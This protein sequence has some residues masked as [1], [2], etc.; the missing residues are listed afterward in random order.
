MNEAILTTGTGRGRDPQNRAV[1]QYASALRAEELSGRKLA[2]WAFLAGIAVI[3][4]WL[5]LQIGAPRVY[6][7][8]AILALF[9]L[10]F[11]ADYGLSRSRHA[12]SWHPYLFSALG[13]ALLAFTLVVPNPFVENWPTQMRLRFGNFV[14][15]IVFLTPI[16]LSYSPRLMLWSGFAAVVAWGVGVAWVVALDGTVTWLDMPD[17]GRVPTSDELLAFFL[18]PG[19]VDLEARVQEIIVVLLVA[20]VL[21]LVVW[22]SRRLVMRQ[23][24]VARER[25]NLARYFPP[26]VVDQLADLDEPFGEVRSQPVAVMFADIVGFSKLAENQAPDEVIAVLR[27]F[28][29]RLE[30]DIF[31]HG[32]TLDKFLGDGVMATFGTPN[33][34]PQDAAHALDCA[35]AILET[36]GQWNAERAARGEAA[37]KVSIGIHYGE[38]VLGDI[39]SARRLEFA[40]LGDVVNVANRLE[41]LT[42][43]LGCRLVV[44]DAVVQAAKRQAGEAAETLITGL[45]QGTPQSLRGRVEPVGIWTFAPVQ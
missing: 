29:A 13:I 22:R 40:V 30:R 14:Y 19:F 17:R 39:G 15:M 10:I 33:T 31:D 34:G 36:I 11:V 38:A 32:G 23:I 35:R 2:T 24:A 8:Q 1:D 21:A 18:Q 9:A 41:A 4:I 27:D 44:S 43:T 42:R 28:H 26:T 20:G 45:R 16:A 37:V 25:A 12:R 5:F 3:A 7:Y 6:F